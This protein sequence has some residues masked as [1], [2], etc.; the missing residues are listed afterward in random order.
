MA[1]IVIIHERKE[2]KSNVAMDSC[3]SFIID[4][5]KKLLES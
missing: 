2:S 3:V 1:R 5:M 4:D